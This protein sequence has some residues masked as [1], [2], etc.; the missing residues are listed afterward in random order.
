MV[1]L[2]LGVEPK[3]AGELISICDMYIM[4]EG[5]R[6]SMIEHVRGGQSCE[7]VHTSAEGRE[8]ASTWEGWGQGG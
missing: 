5:R 1:S 4:I 8:E 3:Q 6:S 7:D 2:G